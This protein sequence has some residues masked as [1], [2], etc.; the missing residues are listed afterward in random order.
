MQPIG[1]I[2][3]RKDR[4][5]NERY[6]L[7]R[8]RLLALLTVGLLVVAACGDG[9]TATTEA[10]DE[11]PTG[12]TTAGDTTVTAA[13]DTTDT[14]TAD[15]AGEVVDLTFQSL[16]WQEESIAANQALVEAWNEANPNIQ[17]EYLQGSWDSVQDQLLTA[18]ES[19][20]APDLIHY[21]STAIIDFGRR[22][23]LADLSG[24]L[25]DEFEA[26]IREGAWQTVADGDAVYGVPFLQESSLF[27]ANTALFDDA[28]VAVPTIDDPWTWDEFQEAAAQLTTGETYG[29]AFP[30]GSPTN[31]ILNLSM[32]FGGT[33][34]DTADGE[35][36]T[37]FG[38]AEQEVPQ[39]IH[40]MLY[41]DNTAA[42]DALGMGSSDVLPGFFG[43]KYAMVT[44]GVWFRQ[45]I[46]S[47]AP[48]GF[49]WVTLPPL[50]GENQQQGATSQT[51]SISVD[52]PHPQEAAA[53]L[54][55]FLSPDGMADL[56]L[57]DWLL[58]TSDAAGEAIMSKT[59]G[60]M[61]WD[62]AVE[63]GEHLVI[64]PFQEVAGFAEWKSEV[65]N[66]ALQ[67]YFADQITLEELGRRLVE[68]GQA[69]LDQ[70]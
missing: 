10:P 62:V 46:E 4:H 23:Y 45:Q 15:D 68:E 66:P 48:D 12:D 30:I 70:Y 25:S 1:Q 54:E 53:F 26:S 11:E 38:A 16:A 61:G 49:E 57:G 13:G 29:A 43:G 34:F 50:V 64:A 56:A 35:A 52:S 24:L 39:R 2:T 33:F 27:F 63:S 41:V 69:V 8:G 59:G 3:G 7:K 19:G 20:E 9:G 60:E 47:Q 40:D 36:T 31:R 67:E 28:G 17:V 14:T 37:V 18:F 21:E 55:F 42:T 22:G 65:S 6:L 51:I 58:P 32:S 5:M 44:S